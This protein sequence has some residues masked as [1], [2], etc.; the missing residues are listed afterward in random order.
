[1]SLTSAETFRTS[2]SASGRLPAATSA[3]GSALASDQRKPASSRWT[4]SLTAL[5]CSSFAE[6]S[7]RFSSIH[8]LAPQG[9]LLR[10]VPCARGDS[11]LL[12]LR[13]VPASGVR[14][15]L[16]A[17][18]GRHGRRRSDPPQQRR[19]LSQKPVP[20]Q[21]VPVGDT[22][23]RHQDSSSL[24]QRVA[25]VPGPGCLEVKGAQ[26][27]QHRS[28]REVV[29]PAGPCRPRRGVPEVADPPLVAPYRLA[30]ASELPGHV[31][32]PLESAPPPA[33]PLGPLG[34]HLVE[35][36]D[37]LPV[38]VERRPPPGERPLPV[39]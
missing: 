1:M 11:Q 38:A 16:P 23:R 27:Q 36:A 35:E 9:P 31:S 29:V 32:R 22:G 19:A 30:G 6:S 21:L 26:M 4:A 13:I 3:A 24:L 20:H 34:D 8:L 28:E 14:V 10:S 39:P 12:P 17:R 33:P 18:S 37:R 2:T 25:G 15:T 7:S 5:S